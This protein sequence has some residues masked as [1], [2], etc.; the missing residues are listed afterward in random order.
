M[1]IENRFHYE[2]HMGGH[3]VARFDEAENLYIEKE[4]P[5]E[6]GYVILRNGE[7]D[8]T[9]SSWLKEMHTGRILKKRV[10]IWL[11]YRETDLIAK[12]ALISACPVNYIVSDS[13]EA[14]GEQRIEK[15]ELDYRSIDKWVV[16]TAEEFHSKWYSMGQHKTIAE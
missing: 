6:L 7:G 1:N 15:L 8:D 16:N 4:I 10:E 13:D 14:S 12:W 2:V 11:F 9:F 5:Q 3:K